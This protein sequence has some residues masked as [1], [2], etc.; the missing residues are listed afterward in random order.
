MDRLTSTYMVPYAPFE[1]LI[2]LIINDSSMGA[3]MRGQISIHWI[4]VNHASAITTDK[5]P[6]A[7]MA[8]VS[9]T[10]L[11]HAISRIP[12]RHFIKV[13]LS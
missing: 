12:T 13:G 7:T 4:E 3:A 8:E 1:Q 6:V 11:F 10:F 5:N 9:S 2:R